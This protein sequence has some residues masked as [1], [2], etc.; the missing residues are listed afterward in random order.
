M[1]LRMLREA[2]GL[3]QS[4]LERKSGVKLK[5][6]QAYEQKYRDIGGMSLETAVKLADALG[7]SDLRELLQEDEMKANGREIT[8]VSKEV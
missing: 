2:A 1:G 7:I 6:I 5:A 3:S 8:D 4:Q